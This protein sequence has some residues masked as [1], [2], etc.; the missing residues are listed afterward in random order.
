MTTRPRVGALAPRVSL[1][2]LI[3]TLSA[4]GACEREEALPPAPSA[5][6]SVGHGAIRVQAAPARLGQLERQITATGLTVAWRDANLRA[7]AGGQVVALEV[8]NG[9]RV[10]AGD[11][12]L[13]V[14]GSRQ[15]IAVSGA[16]ARVTALEQDVELAR[17]DFERKQALATKGS[18]PTAQLDVARLNLERAEAALRGANADLGSARR[19]TRDT[20]ISAPIAGLVT[21]RHADLG[22]TIGAG[23]PLLDIVDLSRVRVHVGLA[24]A[25]IARLDRDADVQIVIE[26]LGGREQLGRIA[27]VAP[28]ADPVTGLFDVELHLDNADES[29]RGGMVASVSLPLRGGPERVLVPRAALTRRGGK[30]AVFVLEPDEPDGAGSETGERF[31]VARLREVRAGA[32]GDDLVEILAGV[33]VGEQVATTTQHALADAVL[34]EIDAPPTDP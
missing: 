34:V 11:L 25:E 33:E 5:A 21:N 4:A 27:A 6:L 7:E 19:A 29:V 32:Y 15:R 12:L 22:D 16:S 17:T 9:D 13:R 8:D 26:D 30:L 14:D 23:T 31:H 1:V 20:R 28:T 10:E 18:L 2:S 24:G 3:A